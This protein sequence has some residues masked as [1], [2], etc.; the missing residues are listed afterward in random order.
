MHRLVVSADGAVD[1]PGEQ[2]PLVPKAHVDCLH[3]DT[4]LLRDGFYRRSS[5]PA[6]DKESTRS[7]QYLQTSLL[8]LRLATSR[9]VATFLLFLGH[10]LLTS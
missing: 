4:S 6:S 2:R 9:V 1:E 10:R 5:E 3:R 8:R 7:H